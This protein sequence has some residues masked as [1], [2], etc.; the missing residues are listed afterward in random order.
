[1]DDATRRRIEAIPLFAGLPAAAISGIVAACRMRRHARGEHVLHHQESTSDIFF[2]LEG[3]V[4]VVIYAPNGRDVSFRD[5]GV[6]DMFGELAA[7]DQQPRSASVVA[8]EDCALA[9][10]GRETFL[11]LVDSQPAV[12]RSLLTHFVRLIRRYSHL[13]YELSA[14]GVEERVRAELLRLAYEHLSGED[15]ARFDPA[16]TLSDVAAR[17]GTTRE[18][19]SREISRLTRDGIVTRQGKALTVNSLS[20]LAERVQDALC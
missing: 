16:P 2:V 6:G 5:L 8:I 7:I 11:R 14:I 1:M 18:A 3:R 4:R 10:F 9:S 12:A 15:S 20:A 17:I 19:V 13:V